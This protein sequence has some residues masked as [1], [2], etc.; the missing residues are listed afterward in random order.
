MYTKLCIQCH[1][2]D[3]Y[4]SSPPKKTSK[5]SSGCHMTQGSELNTFTA[6]QC[7]GC[8]AAITRQHTL[9]TNRSRKC[10]IQLLHLH[11]MSISSS[12]SIFSCYGYLYVSTCLLNQ[13]VHR[14]CTMQSGVHIK[15]SASCWSLQSVRNEKMDIKFNFGTH[16]HCNNDFEWI[17]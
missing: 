2:G 3:K 8:Q 12:F 4:A 10:T 1:S 5:P 15:R 13:T 11:S 9:E 17:Y 14:V 16:C 7:A 6:H